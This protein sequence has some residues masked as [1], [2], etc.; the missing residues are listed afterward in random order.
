MDRK[1]FLEK[2]VDPT[3]AEAKRILVGK[4]D[5]YSNAQEVTTNFRRNAEKL[6]LS[7]YSVHAVYMGKHLDSIER[8][9]RERQA[10]NW[11]KM[12]EPIQ[13]R[14]V[15]VINYLLLFLAIDHEEFQKH[16][17]P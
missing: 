11:P 5:E 3:L 1:T 10:G 13:G 8:Y 15:D 2:I 12:E 17:G 9:I 7:V 16:L 14:V 4:G 6:G